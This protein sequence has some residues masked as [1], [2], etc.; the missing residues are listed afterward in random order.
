M[1]AIINL[2]QLLSSIIWGNFIVRSA[3]KQN[4]LCTPVH[5]C[6]CLAQPWKDVVHPYVPFEDVGSHAVWG[7]CEALLLQLWQYSIFLFQSTMCFWDTGNDSSIH[8]TYAPLYLW[9]GCELGYTAAAKVW[10]H[11]G[12]GEQEVGLCIPTVTKYGSTMLT[13]YKLSV[14]TGILE[15]SESWVAP[16]QRAT[17]LENCIVGVHT[18]CT[19]IENQFLRFLY[20]SESAVEGHFIGIWHPSIQPMSPGKF[21]YSKNSTL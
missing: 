20:S 3:A 8:Q 2:W 12:K 6:R 5:T 7:N 17:I 18:L 21:P 16:F 4:H 13:T 1:T 15:N 10:L 14:Q 11:E 9:Y 19:F